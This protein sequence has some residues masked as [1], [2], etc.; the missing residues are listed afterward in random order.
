MQPEVGGSPRARDPAVAGSARFPVTAEGEKE[1][2]ILAAEGEATARLRVAQGE[3]Q[4]I[5]LVTD[6]LGATG[7][8]AQYLIAQRYLESL[9][10]IAANPQKIVFLP[11][12]GA[13]VMGSIAAMR[14]LFTAAAPPSP[15]KASPP[16]PPK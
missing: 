10:R 4:A 5:T 15:P 2:A 3:A 7:N 13:G 6:A 11:Y 14:E 16:L 9:T 12:E 1:S 8:S